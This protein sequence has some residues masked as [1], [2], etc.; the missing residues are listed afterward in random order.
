MSDEDF[1][2]WSV[3]FLNLVDFLLTFLGVDS[4]GF[5][6][7]SNLGLVRFVFV[8]GWFWAFVGKIGF[9]GVFMFLWWLCRVFLRNDGHA[10]GLV[11]GFFMD[12]FGYGVFV[13][14]LWVFVTNVWCLLIAVV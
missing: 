11:S 1:V 8:N 10:F 2:F 5:S 14:F 13:S 9:V 7:E 12:V 3:M 6:V 4:F